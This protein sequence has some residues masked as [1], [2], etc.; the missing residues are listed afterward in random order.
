MN[1]VDAILFQARINPNG[2]AI[3]TPGTAVECITYGRLARQIRKLG[4]V[5]NGLDLEP[6]RVVAVCIRDKIFH[7]VVV[8]GLMRMGIVTISPPRAGKLPRELAVEAIITDGSA[9]PFE[10]SGR[11][12][13]ANPS[14][15]MDDSR[16]APEIRIEPVQPGAIGRIMVTPGAAEGAKSIALTHAN[17]LGRVARDPC[18]AGNRF[19]HSA[20]LYCDLG[21]DTEPGFHYLLSML[22]R[23]GTVYLFGDSIESL[24]Q[25]YDLHKIQSIVAAPAALAEQVT[26]FEAH[27]IFACSFDH[28]LTVDGRL[29]RTLSARVRARM[30]PDLFCSYSTAETGMIA[31]G[32][33]RL[34]EETPEAVGFVTPGV[35]VEIVDD[36]MRVLAPGRQGSV[37][38]RTPDTIAGYLG[39][40]EATEFRNGWFYP[41]DTGVV[42]PDGVLSILGRGA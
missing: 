35:T 21:L 1:I 38:I 22:C 37:R 13:A 6:G 32:P 16:A 25:A 36:A 9:S 27:A 26:L 39:N 24:L 33:A 23:G 42:T 41:G 8:L 14:W 11:V 2:I 4:H 15:M 5:A 12:I 17:M 40:P 3:C 19:A 34:L 28:I 18:P 31:L 29:G 10:N 20:R 7:A 30:T